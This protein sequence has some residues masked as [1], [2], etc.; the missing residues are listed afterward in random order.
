MLPS[1]SRILN[2]VAAAAGGVGDDDDDDDEEEEE[3]EQELDMETFDTSKLVHGDEDQK[4]LNSL[5]EFEREAILADRFEKL[6]NAADMKRALRQNKRREREQKK[7]AKAQ[8]GTGKKAGKKKAAQTKAKASAKK[9]KKKKSDTSGDAALA[10]SLT[11]TRESLRNRDASR[12]KAKKAAALKAIRDERS[13]KFQK[14]ESDS[15]LDYGDEGASD[16]DDDYED[17]AAVSKPWLQKRKTRLQRAMSSEESSDEEE[18]DREGRSARDEKVAATFVQA[19]LEDYHKVTIPRR[20]LARWCNEPFFEDAVKDMYVRLAIGK[21]KTKMKACYRLC[22]IVGVESKPAEYKF[23]QMKNENPVSTNKVLKLKFG[24]SVKPFFMYMVSDSKPTEDDVNKLVGQL[25]NG[26]LNDEI[27]SKK[28]AIKLRKIQDELVTNYTY[29]KED[30]EKSIAE[31]KKRKV[32]NIAMERTR[33]STA[34]QAAREAVEDAE[35]KLDEAKRALLEA[36]ED[37]LDVDQLQSS[38]TLA[39][40]A[41]DDAKSEL[42]AREQERDRILSADESRKKRMKGAEKIQSWNK[43]NERAMEKNKMAD[44]ESYKQQRELEKKESASQGTPKFNPYA[45][46]KVKPKI[47]WEVGQKTEED[48]AA[49]ERE[50]S[51]A[52]AVGSKQVEHAAN[53]TGEEG[54]DKALLANMNGKENVNGKRENLDVAI[55]DELLVRGSGVGA[56][57]TAGDDAVGVESKHTGRRIRKGLSLAEYQAKK[58]TGDL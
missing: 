38:V 28:R 3:E 15:D 8:K 19:E 21:D 24:T 17:E 27:L 44:Y 41:L 32:S 46:R 36:D 6:K 40:E 22:Q 9:K 33:I 1:S 49:E 30:I 47:L 16:S 43:V 54:G 39:S 45:R 11:A 7:L 10:A 4:N 48:A 13:S 50:T 5:P 25:K 51:E 18:D 57:L 53:V 29:T 31:K 55:D 14:D 52:S 42:A 35:A 2:M 23:P 37:D 56:S 58:Q 26:R 20:R 34:V 12:S